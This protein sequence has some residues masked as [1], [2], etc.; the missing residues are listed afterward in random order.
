MVTFRDPKFG[1]QTFEG[2]GTGFTDRFSRGRIEN[3]FDP[4]PGFN[5]AL[6][7][8]ISPKPLDLSAAKK[9]LT[10]GSVGG[11]GG[12]IL[13]GLAGLLFAS[14]NAI[15]S[16]EAAG[17]SRAL[18]ITP[19]E[20]EDIRETGDIDRLQVLVQNSGLESQPSNIQ[21][22]FSDDPLTQSAFENI[23]LQEEQLGKVSELTDP[24]RQAGQKGLG[25]LSNLAFGG[26]VDYQPSKLFGQQL[27]SGRRGILR[28]QAGGGGIKSSRT[29]ERLSDLVSGLAA[30]DVG[31]FESGQLDLLRTGLRAED[32]LRQTGGQTGQTV[33]NIF[34]NLGQGL[35][36]AEQQKGQAALAQSQ[37]LAGGVRGLGDLFQELF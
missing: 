10:I 15:T 29:F 34:G 20:L 24:F 4:S 6:G 36:L 16:D 30:E 9:G 26:D 3:R 12:S 1:E 13:G 35:N 22:Q 18:N 5:V 14:G 32:V 7:P 27:E 21:G 28:Q 11:V 37:T 19:R 2:A 23:A 8:A 33:G 17:I 31:R 25:A